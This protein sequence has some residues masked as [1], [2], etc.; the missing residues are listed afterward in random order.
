[1]NLSLMIVIT[2]NFV[3][4]NSKLS[5]V[6][7]SIT[8]LSILM[9]QI[10][11]SLRIHQITAI[12]SSIV[13]FVINSLLNNQVLISTI[14]QNIINL[15]LHLNPI[16]MITQKKLIHCIIN[17]KSAINSSYSL[18]ALTSIIEQNMMIQKIAMTM[19]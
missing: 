19:K 5:K 15:N 6:L 17:V 10:M 16:L 13:N 18:K 4:K 2:V 7:I 11:K 14:K 1:M 3:T 12:Y 8:G 9:I